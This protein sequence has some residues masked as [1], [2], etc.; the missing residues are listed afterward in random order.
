M[1]LR[2]GFLVAQRFLT[3][4]L[5]R[6]D[7]PA[8]VVARP[9]GYIFGK[10]VHEAMGDAADAAENAAPGHFDAPI[11]HDHLLPPTSYGQGWML[12]GNDHPNAY[13]SL[14]SEPLPTSY[15]EGRSTLLP[16]FYP[17][18]Y[19]GAAAKMKDDPKGRHEPKELLDEVESLEDPLLI[20]LNKVCLNKVRL[21]KAY[22][23]KVRLNKVCLTKVRLNK[24][25][26]TK[27]HLT[28]LRLAGASPWV[29]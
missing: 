2:H 29:T 22:L 20:R 14:A 27:V 8:F 9:T 24:V 7:G 15:P 6:L 1:R 21:N 10:A 23:N 3:L 17:R 16:I 5:H 28:K 11:Q 26:L 18:D 13:H 19:H 12:K 25:R 4:A